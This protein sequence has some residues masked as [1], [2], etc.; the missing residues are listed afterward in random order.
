[1][2]ENFICVLE[3]LKLSWQQYETAVVLQLNPVKYFYTSDNKNY[4]KNFFLHCI[5]GLE[6]LSF[7]A[8][9]KSKML[10]SALLKILT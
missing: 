9:R 4:N 7:D 1:M 3:V 2:N 8:D 5:C 10:P 6:P